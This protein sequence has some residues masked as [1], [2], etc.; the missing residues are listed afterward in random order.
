MALYREYGISFLER[1]RGEFALVLYDEEAKLVI[2]A[3][4]RYGVKPLY[5]TVVNGRLLVS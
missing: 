3:G 2:A 5:Y 4:D 1:L